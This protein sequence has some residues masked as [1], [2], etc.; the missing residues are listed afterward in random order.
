MVDQNTELKTL[1]VVEL[2]Q[3]LTQRQLALDV[4]PF[5]PKTL[6]ILVMQLQVP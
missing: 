2:K 3:E 4:R 5:S 6:P 1:T